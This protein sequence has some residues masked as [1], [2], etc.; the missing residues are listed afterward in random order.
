M[1]YLAVLY[2]PKGL[3]RQRRYQDD[4]QR[5]A[6]SMMRVFVNDPGCS[7]PA[8]LSIDLDLW[9]YIDMGG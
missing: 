1:N 9:M 8:A 5:A 3:P 2:T 7:G 4:G 6:G